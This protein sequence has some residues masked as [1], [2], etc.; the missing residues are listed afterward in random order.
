[1]PFKIENKGGDFKIPP[2][3]TH[4]ARCISIIDLGTQEIEWQGKKKSQRKIR[5]SWEL[6]LE[7]EVFGEGKEPQPFIVSRDYTLSM[8][9][10]AALRKD[11]ES[12][13][14]KK[15][16]E[17]EAEWFDETKV[18][19]KPCTLTL[20]HNEKG[21]KTYANISGIAGVM[22]GVNYPAQINQTV[23]YNTSEGRNT[24]FMALPDWIKEKIEKSPEFREATGENDYSAGHEYG[25]Q[26]ASRGNGSLPAPE[27]DD[28][29]FQPNYL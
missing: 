9:D 1:M 18:V 28:I 16:T 22:R 6:P 26:D 21:G 24:T 27:D 15:F 23:V 20:V 19:G 25:D 4:P 10:A 17:K 2:A 5:F 3:G 12:W 29:P 8:F 14:G 7:L 11:L 13:R